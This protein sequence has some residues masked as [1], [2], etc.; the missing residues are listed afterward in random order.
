MAYPFFED[1]DYTEYKSIVLRAGAPDQNSGKFRDELAAGL[2][3]GSDVNFL[4][5][6]YKP[7]SLIHI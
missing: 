5:Q 6:A 4:Y 2:L 1:L 3:V 7:L